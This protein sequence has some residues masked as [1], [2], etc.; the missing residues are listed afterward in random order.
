MKLA[1]KGTSLN[2]APG[3]KIYEAG[4]LV[5]DPCIF[6][7]LEGRVEITRRYNP[8][9]ADTFEYGPGSVIGM[10]EVYTDKERYTEATSISPVTAIGFSRN[11]FERN[12]VNDLNFA[13]IPIRLMSGMLRQLNLRI[14]QLD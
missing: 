9:Q 1:E 7:I 12:M 2:F 4:Y 6:L 5:A 13:M 8:L 3:D 11:E 14:K 10:L